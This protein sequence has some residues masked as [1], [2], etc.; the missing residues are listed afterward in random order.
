M[1]V[2]IGSLAEIESE[3]DVAVLDQWGVLHDGRQPYEASVAALA[4][5]S[6]AGKPVAV[7]SNSGKRSDVNRKRIEAMGIPPQLIGHVE[8]SGETAWRDFCGGRV[9]L[10]GRERPRLFPVAQA[11]CDPDDWADG[12]TGV[13][14]VSKVGSAD[15][16]LL[17]GMPRGGRMAEAESA[18]TEALRL[19]L[20]LICTNPDKTSPLGAQFVPSPGAV[21]DDYSRN[22]GR[23]IHY[24][25]PHAAVFEAVRRRHP[26]VKRSRFLMV[27][28][29]LEHDIAGARAAGFLS[30]LV[31]CGIHKPELDRMGGDAASAVAKLA[32]KPGNAPPDYT[33]ARLA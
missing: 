19:S 6:R 7:L 21:A 14:L 15:A 25:K 23:V 1:P 29:S 22:G 12:N 27:G 18:L 30:A 10:D 17:M 33:L 28:D 32:A 9:N 8:T 26:G 16:V 3:F 20:P 11:Q 2:P 4:W 13:E 24:G 5:L 31:R